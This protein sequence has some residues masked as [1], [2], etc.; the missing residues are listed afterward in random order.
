[1]PLWRDHAERRA[2]DLINVRRIRSSLRRLYGLA[3]WSVRRGHGSFLTLEFGRPHLRLREPYRSSAKSK[4]VR[5]AAAARLATVHG[6]WHL[7]IYCCDWAVFEGER[8]VGDSRSKQSIDRAARFLDG[9]RLVKAWVVPR[10]MR[11]VFEFDLGGRLET[12]PCDRAREQW[13]LYEPNGNVLA[14]RADRKYSY[15][16]GERHPSAERW[17]AIDA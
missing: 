13:L 8:L 7:W 9:Q 14:I 15:G 11:S 10:G 17:L 6:D 5:A 3:C 2:E 4:R 16:P 1:M 12:K